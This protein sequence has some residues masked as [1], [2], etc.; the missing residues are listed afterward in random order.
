M[1]VTNSTLDWIWDLLE[2]GSS[3]PGWFHTFDRG[4]QVLTRVDD[5]ATWSRLPNEA[6]WT[7]ILPPVR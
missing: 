2:R 4:R 7:S 1:E 3:A 6:I 5:G